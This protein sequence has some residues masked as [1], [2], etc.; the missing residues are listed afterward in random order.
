MRSEGFAR[1][2][3]SLQSAKAK[4]SEREKYG[5][6]FRLSLMCSLHRV[7]QSSVFRHFRANKLAINV[8]LTTNKTCTSA[9]IF[10]DYTLQPRNNAHSRSQA[11]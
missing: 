10:I 2:F 5:L 3:K 6:A 8:K 7:S 4:T 1:K 11:K 9:V